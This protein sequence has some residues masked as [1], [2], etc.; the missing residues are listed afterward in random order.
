[1]FAFPRFLFFDEDWL[2]ADKDDEDE[3]CLEEGEDEEDDEDEDWLEDGEG[4]DCLEGGGAEAFL[5]HWTLGFLSMTV[6]TAG[7][8]FF[9][10]FFF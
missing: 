1:M 2:V 7:L 5:F 6:N 3:D 10:F 4:E 9:V 8:T